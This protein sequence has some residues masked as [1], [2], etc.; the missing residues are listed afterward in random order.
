[1]SSNYV[2]FF[3]DFKD[4]LLFIR[5]GMTEL[6]FLRMEIKHQGRDVNKIYK[7]INND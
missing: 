3:N 7:Y 6:L 4:I 1:M 5:F 2:V